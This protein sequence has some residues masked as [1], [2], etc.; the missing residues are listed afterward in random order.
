MQN[1]GTNTNSGAVQAPDHV[2]KGWDRVASISFF[3]LVGLLW[4]QLPIM[5]IIFLTLF[6]LGMF[7]VMTL[8]KD[9]TAQGR[10]LVQFGEEYIYNPII[11]TAGQGTAYST[12]Q[13]IQAEVGFFTAVALKERVLKKLGLRRVYPELAVKYEADPSS[14]PEILAMAIHELDK[15]LGAY[16]APNQPLISISYRNQNPQVSADVLNAV[17]DEYLTYRREVLLD[18]GNGS[19]GKERETTEGKL[20]EINTALALFL[21]KNGIGDFEAERLAAG[22]RYGALNDLLLTAKARRREI[23]AGIRAREDR[24]VLVPEKILQFTD[25][26]SSAELSA[27]QIEREQLLA[28]Y[29]PRSKPVQAID[30]RIT[31]LSSFIAN[32]ENKNLGTKRTGVNPVHQTLQSEKLSLEAEAQSNAERI[33]VLTAQ[34]AQVRRKQTKLQKLFPEYQ[35]LAGKVTVLQTAVQQFS[36]REEEFAARRNLAEQASNNIRIIERPVVPYQGKSMKKPAAILAFLF[37]G[38]TALMVGLAIVFAQL[39]KVSK[40]SGQMPVGERFASQPVPPNGNGGVYM[41][42]APP[43][44]Y[45]AMPAHPV[46][47]GVP[48]HAAN[49]M[50]SQRVGPGGLP[51]I[52]NI[53]PKSRRH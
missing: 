15:S 20:D 7:A 23:D 51:I 2:A 30:A 46:Q 22:V 27:L 10:I 5:L 18:D 35:R 17:I 48:L 41:Q 53:A 38:F 19:Y 11:G 50:Q 21:N 26:T 1:A 3:E 16:T 31:R 13:M 49:Q 25:N 14:R 45:A 44:V 12:D 43:P 52:A 24:L 36:T 6:V 42:D 37:A 32:G 29:K 39:A 4:R 34:I 33:S 47:Y 9:Y 8:K 40:Q 28:R